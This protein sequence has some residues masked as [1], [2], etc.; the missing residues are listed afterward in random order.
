MLYKNNN[1]KHFQNSYKM[2]S[3]EDTLRKRV[4][5]FHEKDCDKPKTFRVDHFEAEGVP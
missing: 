3:K 2:T 1:L 5:A 4:Y